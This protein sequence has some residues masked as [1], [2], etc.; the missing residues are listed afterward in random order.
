MVKMTK[1]RAGEP[2]TESHW[3]PNSRKFEQNVYSKPTVHQSH[4]IQLR[5][6]H[7]GVCQ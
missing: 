7:T 1:G 5:I 3:V 6:V 2:E 4:K